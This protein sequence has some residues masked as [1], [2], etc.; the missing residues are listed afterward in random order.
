MS[1]DK[2][3]TYHRAVVEVDKAQYIRLRGKLLTERGLTISDWVR[4]S[5]AKELGEEVKA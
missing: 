1:K 4:I 2:T 5:I 3:K